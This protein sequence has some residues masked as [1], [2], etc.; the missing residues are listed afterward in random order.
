MRF[1]LILIGLFLLNPLSAFA[2]DKTDVIKAL[3][4]MHKA[5]SDGNADGIRDAFT[6]DGVFL[7][8]DATEAW[9]MAQLHKDLSARFE[10][11]GG[12]TFEI[13]ERTVGVSP[14]GNTAWFK[15]IANLVQANLVLR[16]TGTMIKLDGQWKITQLHIGVPIPNDIYGAF[17]QSLQA[18][19]SDPKLEK[20]AIAGTLDKLHKYASEAKGKEYFDLFMDDGVFIG[21]DLTERWPIPAFKA[22]AMKRFNTGVGWTYH[23]VERTIDITPSGTTAYFDEN[24]DSQL[25]GVARGSGVL[26]RVNGNWKIAQYHLTYPIPNDLSKKLTDI[27][28]EY[29]AGKK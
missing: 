3:E 29:E 7:G 19:Q 1:A 13:M 25:Y 21:T 6:T 4:A 8:T 11:Q 23:A 20:A 5:E 26:V 27:I 17:Q 10:K 9:G 15:E 2:D 16:P 24:L 22:Y 28:K 18:H 12:W 14:D